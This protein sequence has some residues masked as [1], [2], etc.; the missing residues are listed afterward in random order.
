MA[1][2]N[3]P[4]VIW[5]SDGWAESCGWA[6]AHCADALTAEYLGPQDVWVSVGTGLP[7]G[8]YLDA[9]PLPEEGQAVVRQADGWAHVPDYRGVTVYDTATHQPTAITALGPL[10]E[11]CTLLAPSSPYDVWDGAAWQPDVAATEQAVLTA[12][13]AEQSR[14]ISVANKQIAIISPAVEGGYAKPEHTKL[15]ADW[16]RYRYELTLVQEQVSWP[17]SPQWP[18]EPNKV[19]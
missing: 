3:E 1:A 7:A 16:Q 6:Q 2:V 14:R 10:S 12:A 17:G 4:R 11:G 13:Q 18:A 8:A 9:P 5:G 15:L 19:I